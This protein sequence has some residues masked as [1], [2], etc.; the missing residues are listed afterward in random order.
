MSR[1]SLLFIIG[2][3]ASLS[4]TGR[5]TPCRRRVRMR[6]GSK[7]P[8]LLERQAARRRAMRHRQFR[9]LAVLSLSLTGLLTTVPRYTRF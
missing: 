5:P 7:I 3:I 8:A 9:E 1:N 4:C 6:T 2:L